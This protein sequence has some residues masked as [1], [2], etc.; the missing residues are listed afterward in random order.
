MPKSQ[1]QERTGTS[2]SILGGL[3]AEIFHSTNGFRTILY[4]I[5]DK[6]SLMRQD[7]LGCKIRQLLDDLLRVLGLAKDV[8]NTLFFIK[9]EISTMFKAVFSKFLQHRCLAYLASSQHHQWLAVSALFPLLQF[10]NN[11]SVK[12][13][14]LFLL[15]WG[16]CGILHIF[17]TFFV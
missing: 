7:W 1:P 16:K 9:T 6:Q 10:V 12:H 5:K 3:F 4:L 17:D 13:I 14:P 8:T 15:K 11:R 2:H